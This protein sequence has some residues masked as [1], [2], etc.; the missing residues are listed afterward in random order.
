MLLKFLTIVSAVGVCMLV[1]AVARTRGQDVECSSEV[2]ALCPE[3]PQPVPTYLAD[4]EDCTSYCECD[5]TTAF[6]FTCDPGLLYNDVIHVCDW[7]DNVDCGTRPTA[8]SI[9]E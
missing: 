1:V 4:P 7:P 8:S 9:E 3:G 6:H 2:S 5:G